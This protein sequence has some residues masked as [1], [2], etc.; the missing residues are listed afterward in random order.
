MVNEL[1]Y[2][3][4]NCSFDGVEEDLNFILVFTDEQIEI[5]RIFYYYLYSIIIFVVCLFGILGN[6]LNVIIFIK[7]KNIGMLDEVE[8]CTIIC[9]VFFVVFDMMFCIVIFFVGF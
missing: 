7:K 8:Y 2:L 1:Y 5:V 3:I 4:I 6:I 9:L